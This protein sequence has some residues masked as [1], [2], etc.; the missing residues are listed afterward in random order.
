MIRIRNTASRYLIF[1]NLQKQ[2]VVFTSGP[3]AADPDCHAT[4]AATT[5]SDAELTSSAL[6]RFLM[7]GPLGSPYLRILLGLLQR[8]SRKQHAMHM[9][10]PADHPIEEVGRNLLA[11]LLK[12]QGGGLPI[13]LNI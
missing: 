3:T 7:D 6:L 11:V 12:H 10:F 1:D 13:K 9:E 5:A 8:L 2:L 4:T